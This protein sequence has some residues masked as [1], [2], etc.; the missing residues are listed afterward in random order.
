MN[1]EIKNPLVDT[2]DEDTLR[3]STQLTFFEK[4]GLVCAIIVSLGILVFASLS[5]LVD[6][7]IKLNFLSI[8]IDIFIVAMCLAM[9]YFLFNILRKKVVTEVLIDTAFQHGVYARL[10]SLIENIVTSQ[11]GTDILMDRMSDLDKKVENLSKERRPE[12]ESIGTDIMQ[13][14]IALGTSVKFMIKAIFMVVLTMSV[15]IFFVNFNIGIVTPYATLSMFILWWLFITNEYSLWK[16]NGT[17]TFAFFPII[18]TPVT[19]IVLA[20]VVNYNI[21]IAL[22]YASIGIYSFVYYIWA[23]YKTTGNL[24]FVTSKRYRSEESEFFASQQRNMFRVLLEEAINK[25]RP[26]EKR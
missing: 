24:P 13:E 10:Q 16:E 23:I 25:I 3:M 4:I 20:N 8:L 14:S 12:V 22:L 1:D 26:V 2:A 9:I 17:W 5:L 6:I 11:V 19:V 21:L 18:M 15:F 7:L